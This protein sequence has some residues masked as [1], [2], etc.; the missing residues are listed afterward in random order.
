MD[1]APAMRVPLMREL[2][3]D[4]KPTLLDN[5]NS[6][7][8]Y[9]RHRWRGRHGHQDRGPFLDDL[10]LLG[11][12]ERSKRAPPTTRLTCGQRPTGCASTGRKSKTEIYYQARRGS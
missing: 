1:C 5:D 11:I 10:A 3:D 6:P 7:G 2:L 9:H 8:T 4:D 12:A